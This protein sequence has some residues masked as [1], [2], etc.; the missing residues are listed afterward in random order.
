MKFSTLMVSVLGTAALVAACKGKGKEDPQGA[1]PGKTG[2]GEG[3]VVDTAKPSDPGTATGA[4][5]VAK[6]GAGDGFACA[7]MDSGS[8]RCW[9][10]NDHGERGTAKS[11]DDA[12]TPVEVPGLANVVDLV[13]GGDSGSSGDVSCA[14]TKD[15]DV[16]CW[17]GAA[18]LPGK[19]GKT[20]P[21]AIAD[22]KGALSIALGGGTGYAVKADGTVW[23]WGSPAF[24]SLADGTTSGGSDKPLT[25]I[26]GITGAKQVAA[27]QNHGCALLGDGTVTCWG[28]VGKKQLPTAI[29]GVT[30][31]TALFAQT[32][33][34][35]TCAL[36]KEG[37]VCWG[38]SQAVKPMA[39]LA[40][41]TKIAGRN[42]LCALGGDGSVWCWGGDNDMGQLGHAGPPHKPGKVEGL[43]KKAT[44]IAVGH[45]FT[46]AALEDGSAACWGYNQRGQLGDGTLTDRKAPTAVAGVT[47][48]KLA[49]AKDGLTAVQEGPTAT[50]WDGLP[51]KCKNGPIELTAKSYAGKGFVVKGAQAKRQLGGKTVEIVLADHQLH[52]G[53]AQ[54]R[55]TQGKLG[56]RLAKFTI[57]GDK[58]EAAPVDLGEYTLGTKVERMVSP[59][60]ETK[61]G[62]TNLIDFSLA[63]G[64]DVGKL[65]LTHL[66][67]KWVCGELA[68]SAGGSSVK[69]P[70]A[71]P[72]A[73]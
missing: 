26:P 43:A 41:V 46:C 19:D 7:V 60:L 28:Y 21:R 8:V 31:A 67:D 40:G 23:G 50:A 58:R 55:G 48:D 44:D 12:A 29:A 10:Q 62:S 47:A 54:P 42:H 53:W 16:W 5:K 4:R 13:A 52:A 38:E 6:L 39:E 51:E 30:G 27:G 34:D 20:E 15:K 24:N 45:V 66:D 65:T 18:M 72:I 3:K 56:L 70:F 57:Q 69:G 1:E 71:A 61:T 63:G 59:T 2:S 9:G 73:P 22:L 14:I 32:Q 11:T 64:V 17:G 35:T 37:T 25:Q 49:A 36:A 33:R 68:L